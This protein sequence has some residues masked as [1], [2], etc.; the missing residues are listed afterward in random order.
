MV[1]IYCTGATQVIN[2]RQQRQYNNIWRR[3]QCVSCKAIFTT[4]EQA[5]LAAGLMV[6][7]GA[8]PRPQPFLRDKLFL[9]IHAS[10]QHRA[11]A[12]QEAAELTRTVIAKLQARPGALIS[13]SEITHAATT[14]LHRFDPVAATFYKAYHPLALESTI[15]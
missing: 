1:C 6:K 8:S 7:A 11:D 13:P 10:C 14:V 12:L 3:R 4:H 15:S 2:S 9:S 5:D